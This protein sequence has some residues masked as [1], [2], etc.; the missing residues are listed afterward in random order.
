M[1]KITLPDLIRN[2]LPGMFDKQLL[3]NPLDTS[4]SNQ[5]QVCIEWLQNNPWLNWEAY[6]DAYPDI[7]V[8][9]INPT[10]HFVNDG[11]FEGR[12]LFVHTSMI[13][14]ND[15]SPLV[16]IIVPNYNNGVFL[17]KSIGS[18]LN[19]TLKN[20]EIIVVDDASTDNSASILASLAESDSRLKVIQHAQNQSQHMARKTG[21][22]ASIGQY[23]MFMDP[24]DYYEP[25]ACETAWRAAAGQYDLVCFGVKVIYVGRVEAWRKNFFTNWFRTKTPKAFHSFEIKTAIIENG[26]MDDLLWNKIYEGDYCKAVFATLEDKYLQMGEDTY[27]AIALGLAA[28]SAARIEDKLYVY[29]YGGGISGTGI[30]GT[31]L[32]ANATAISVYGC[33]ER[34]F[35]ATGNNSFSGRW[36]DTLLGKSVAAWVSIKDAQT[37]LAYF[38]NLS[39]ELG[40][41]ELISG[42]SEQKSA[43]LFSISK[44]FALISPH[45]PVCDSDAVGVHCRSLAAPARR[46]VVFS[47]I[48][49]LLSLG[50]VVNIYLEE[51][52]EADLELPNE[53]NVIY[54]GAFR[55]GQ[56]RLESILRAFFASFQTCSP[57]RM[58]VYGIE[59]KDMLWKLMLFKSLGVR[60][61]VV[62]PPATLKTSLD[63]GAKPLEQHLTLLKCPDHIY[64]ASQLEA[65]RY[66]LLGVKASYLPV[67]SNAPRT[68]DSLG[69]DGRILLVTVLDLSLDDG[70]WRA[71][72][73]LLQKV[74]KEIP[75]IMIAIYDSGK[76]GA[77][78]NHFYEVAS[79]NGLFENFV[80][81]NWSGVLVNCDALLLLNAGYQQFAAAWAAYQRGIPIIT[82]SGTELHLQEDLE[83]AIDDLDSSLAAIIAFL[84]YDPSHHDFLQE[85]DPQ[86][87]N[88]LREA[89][90][91]PHMESS[92]APDRTESLRDLLL[93]LGSAS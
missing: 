52:S 34:L 65:K 13:A 26:E 50:R 85:I 23:I 31:R 3:G 56:E 28:K 35:K 76:N 80:L 38:L 40:I 41:L 91:N 2:A 22:A 17:E 68:M 12:K 89:L 49:I 7:K 92:S 54:L 8:A 84:K 4:R 82:A 16:S 1:S 75:E 30:L 15:S 58:F 67:Q 77:N 24:D 44:A 79:Q 20:I 33:I 18:L 37:S 6:L 27:E 88:G 57:G 42:L 48:Q 62:L 63:P 72:L 39:D 73:D 74:R 70:S 10:V 25:H 81:K 69:L 55:N 59:D 83:F 64:T 86:D 47:H 87:N 11:V 14:K 19:Q 93:Y 36:K 53:V 21:V 66:N 5:T 61:D 45:M 29:R 78:R 32:E 43:S 60:V 9:G 51:A 90:I 46:E 71:L